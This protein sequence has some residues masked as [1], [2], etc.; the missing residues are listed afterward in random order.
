MM[1]LFGKGT[2][3]LEKLFKAIKTIQPPSISCEQEFSIAFSFVQKYSNRLKDK[4][5]FS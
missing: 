3:N 2:P 5:K 4:L 1:I